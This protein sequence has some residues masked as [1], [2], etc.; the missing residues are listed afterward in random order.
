[1]QKQSISQKK[2]KLQSDKKK[3]KRKVASKAKL[4]ARRLLTY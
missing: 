2:A 1:M 3:F 4:K